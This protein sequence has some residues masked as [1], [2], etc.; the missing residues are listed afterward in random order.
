MCS[1]GNNYWAT[2]IAIEMKEVKIAFKILDDSENVPPDHQ[3]IQCHM[4]FDVKMEDFRQKAWLVAGG[5][6]M[7][8]PPAS[9]SR[10]L[11]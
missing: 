5:G 7:T 9:R 10:Y 11:C 2:A 3:F 6:H 4:V 1:N 8:D